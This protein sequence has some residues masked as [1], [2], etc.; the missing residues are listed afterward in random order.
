M[1]NKS[2]K[3]D[4]QKRFPLQIPYHIEVSLQE[5]YDNFYK[6]EIPDFSDNCPICGCANC[7]TYHGHYTRTAI[8]P[9]TGYFM[10]ALPVL[11]FICSQKGN[12]PICDHKTFSLLPFMLVPYRQLSL[13][14]M[15]L[16]I[17]I[18]V[19]RHL[20]LTS[21]LN[22]IDHELNDLKDVADFI[23]ISTVISWKSMIFAATRLIMSTDTEL[24]SNFQN[25]QILDDEGLSL[26]L[27]TIINYDFMINHHPVRGPDA[28]AWEF[29]QQSGGPDNCPVF[30]F[31]LASQQKN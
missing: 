13:R 5:Y 28:L 10:H 1:T 27:K 22:V 6:W 25:E 17:W 7:A 4:N 15:V 3:K 30:L 31:G 23:N 14:F 18:K 19:S 24:L 9:L 11:R 26:F 12:A 29:Y 20:T 2:F 8:C 21:A 16:A